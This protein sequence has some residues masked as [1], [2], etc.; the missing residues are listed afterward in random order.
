MVRHRSDLHQVLAQYTVRAAGHSQSGT[1]P[2]FVLRRGG[3]V[4]RPLVESRFKGLRE[5]TDVKRPMALTIHR[6]CM[7]CATPS[8]FID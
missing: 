7:T 3:P 6:A 5:Y 1:A 8:P 2:F 4:Q